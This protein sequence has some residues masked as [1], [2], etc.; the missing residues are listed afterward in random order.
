MR[1]GSP[2]LLSEEYKSFPALYRVLV[3][4]RNRRWVP[5]IEQLLHERTRLLRGRGRAAPGGRR[6]T[7]GADA[8]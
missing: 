6:R 8:P 2:R 1:R 4:D 7:A 5:Q 3:T